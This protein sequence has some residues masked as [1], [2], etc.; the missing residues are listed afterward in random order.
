[1]Q[2]ALNEK[3][4]LLVGLFSRIVDGSAVA[5]EKDGLSALTMAI[6]GLFLFPKRA[7]LLWSGCVRQEHRYEFPAGLKSKWKTQR[8][9]A[10][11]YRMRNGPP[12]SAFR[13]GQATKPQGWELD[14]IYNEEP[15]WSARN[16]LHFTQSAGLVAMPRHAHLRRH[17]DA[18]LTWL[19]RGVAFVKF[20]YDPLEVFSP[21]AHDSFGFSAGRHCEVFWP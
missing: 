15:L 4:Q 14:H 12:N 13:L 8:S 9:G 11:D 16:G 2:L 6:D 20:G 3:E 19:V 7:V 1:M 10:L 17:S 21:T 5:A 18:M